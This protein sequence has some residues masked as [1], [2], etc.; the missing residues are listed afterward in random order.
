MEGDK[1]LKKVYDH[2]QYTQDGFHV[3]YFGEIRRGVSPVV[4]AL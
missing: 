3:E 1:N 2:C 4:D